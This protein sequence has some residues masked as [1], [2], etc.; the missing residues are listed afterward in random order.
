M[1]TKKQKRSSRK[2]MAS[3]NA[4]KGGR[5]GSHANGGIS[6]EQLAMALAAMSGRTVRHRGGDR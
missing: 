1:F 5:P 2:L 6:P 3:R 4:P